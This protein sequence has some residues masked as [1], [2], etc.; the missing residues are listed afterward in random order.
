MKQFHYVYLTTNLINGKHYV[1]DHST[2][3]LDDG[4]LGSGNI[5]N[6]FKKYGKQNFKK[7]IL[8]YF[9]ERNEAFL[10]Q[11]KYIKE[12]N[13]L[14]PNGYNI[15]PMGGLGFNGCH[16]KETKEKIKQ[17]LKGSKQSKET[18]E[19]RRKKLIGKKRTQETKFKMSKWQIGKI[20]SEKTKIKISKSCI[21]R[22]FS[23]E[24]KIKLSKSCAGRI[25]P[26]L[27]KIQTEETKKKISIKCKKYW[28]SKKIKILV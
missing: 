7:E 20:L 22:K 15:S 6:A 23:E 5:I 8:E 24:T 26:M 10:N 11:E 27:G 1:G 4:Y 25:P 28:V 17:T 21:G 12:Y 16:S 3:N 18:I 14:V 19:K 2:D 13:T 9:N